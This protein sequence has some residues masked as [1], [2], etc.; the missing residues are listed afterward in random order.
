MKSYLVRD[1]SGID[2]LHLIDL[3]WPKPAPG[4]VV[5]RVRACSLNFRDRGILRGGYYRNDRLPVIPLSDMAG[6]V[7]ELGSGVTDFKVGDRVTANLVRDWV[8]G[9]P[10]DADLRTGFGGGID[11]FLREAV[12]LPT[13]CLLKLPDALEFEQA[14]TLP[15]AAVTVWHAFKRAQTRAQQSLLLLGTGGVSVFGLQLGKALGCRCIITSSSDSKLGHARSLGADETIN[16]QKFP[17]WPHVV[18][19]MTGGAGVDQVLEVGGSGTLENSMAATRIGGTV[20]LIGVLAGTN[21]QPNIFPAALDCLNIQG[22]YAGS[23]SMFVDLLRT[24]ARYGI[25]PLIDR[26]FAFDEAIDAYRYFATQAHVGKI[27][28]TV[29]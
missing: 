4:E 24:V 8:D 11:G 6:E 26:V 25:K 19:E 7:V 20:S 1:N 16:Y 29:D 12:A 21:T 17:Q 5:V 28:I 15:C 9:L 13:H 27:V 23:R 14:A 2:S 3:P 18:R 22:I 10:T